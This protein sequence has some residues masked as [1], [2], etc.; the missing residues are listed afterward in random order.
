M[1]YCEIRKRTVRSVE[2]VYCQYPL[3]NN[4]ERGTYVEHMIALALK[5]LQWGLTWPWG[6]WDLEHQDRARIEV[7]QSAARQTWHKRSDPPSQGRFG[8]KKPSEGY[9]LEDGT[10]IETPR[11][12]HADLYVF[13][14]HP[15]KDLRIADHRRPDQW[16]FFVVAESRLPPFPDP[17]PKNPTTIGLNG[18]NAVGPEHATYEAL[19]AMVTKVRE[20]LGKLKADQEECWRS[21]RV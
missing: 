9:E 19:P 6:P 3:I 20:S 14:W 21:T 11:H 13:A 5:E 17:P 18:L 10:R 4:V 2:S 15:E 7:K 8:I 12:R 1:D 16:E